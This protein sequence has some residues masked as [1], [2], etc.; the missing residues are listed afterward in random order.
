MRFN[1][2]HKAKSTVVDGIRFASLGEARRYQELK[3]LKLSH[4]IID[5]KIQPEFLLK[6]DP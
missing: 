3:L 5:F 6:T 2:R 4:L 1:A